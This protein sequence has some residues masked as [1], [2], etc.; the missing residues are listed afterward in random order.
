[1]SSLK[2]TG[3][4]PNA[5]AKLY[6]V[7]EAY[8]RAS[9][10]CTYQER[11]PDEVRER[12]REW[13]IRGEDAEVVVSRLV[14]EDFLNEGRFAKVFA[15]GKFRIKHWGR[16]K[17]RHELRARGLSEGC[18]RQGLLEIDETAYRHTLQHLL[19]KKNDSLRGEEAGARKQKLVRYALGK[20]YENNLVWN[21]VEEIVTS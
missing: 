14:D 3:I 13:N 11:T 16:L 5:E 15:G 17:I 6:D 18:I 12:L 19:E 7:K 21:T 20:G 10:Y 1:M 9:S 4:R 2:K 8:L